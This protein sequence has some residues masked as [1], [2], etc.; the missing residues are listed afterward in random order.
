MGKRRGK[1]EEAEGWSQ[2][3]MGRREKDLNGKRGNRGKEREEGR[4][5]TGSRRR[6]REGGKRIENRCVRRGTCFHPGP[7]VCQDACRFPSQPRIGFVHRTLRCTYDSQFHCTRLSPHC[8]IRER[9]ARSATPH[10]D[11]RAAPLRPA[12]PFVPA[13]RSTALHALRPASPCI[14]S[15][16]AACPSPRTLPRTTLPF[17]RPP[18]PAPTGQLSLE[19]IMLE[20]I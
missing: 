18:H 3:E 16:F 2:R 20:Y 7:D 4:R 19:N 14:P 15:R 1:K 10:A 12:P 11:S 6:R 5:E 8:R 17:H 9:Y 13:I